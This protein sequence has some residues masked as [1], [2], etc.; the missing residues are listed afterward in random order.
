M[1]TLSEYLEQS[2]ITQRQLADAVGV[3]RSYLSEIA[4][5]VKTPS[6]ET[7]LRIQEATGGKVDLHS[8]VQSP[9]SVSPTTDSLPHKDVG[10]ASTNVKGA[11]V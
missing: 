10:S 8:L 3:S 5:R 2:S 11:A 1:T 6:L 4:K 7:A 9:S